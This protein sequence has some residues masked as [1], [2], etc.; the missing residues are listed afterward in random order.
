ME[1]Y[2]LLGCQIAYSLSPEIHMQAWR[3]E[4]RECAYR[5]FDTPD[6]EAFIE[7]VHRMPSLR[8]FNVTTPF[9]TSVIPYLDSVDDTS[10][11][12]GAVNT[13]KCLWQGHRHELHGFN[14]DASGF[15]IYFGMHPRCRS[16][17]ALILGSG[18][19]SLAVQY[20]LQR[21]GMEFLVVSRFGSSGH[22]RYEE[23]TEET[24]G[25][26]RL[27]INCTPLGSRKAPGMLPP[28][29]YD[30]L[31]DEHVLI[32]LT[33]VPTV[34]PFLAEGESRGTTTLNGLPMLRQQARLSRDIWRT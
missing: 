14:T 29:P 1:L 20:A 7:Q 23:I 8:G 17:R 13:V 33:Y 16:M 22:Y 12:I 34:T 30:V 10:A 4:G 27:V 28:L 25:E 15:R 3:E 26:Y 24:L 18:G 32:D 21:E 9:K 11:V 19:A 31:T 5:L 2:G 6:L